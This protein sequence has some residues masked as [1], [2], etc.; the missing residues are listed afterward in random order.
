MQWLEKLKLGLAKT[1]AKITEGIDNV[2]NKRKLDEAVA[3]E[4][5]DLLISA[6][7]GIE[8]SQY[9]V[10]KLVDKYRFH[11]EVSLDEIKHT[12]AQLIAEIL[13]PIEHKEFCFDKK[14]KILIVCGVNGGGKTTSIAKLANFYKLQK[15]SVMLVACDTFRAAAVDQLEVWAN[16]LGITIIK[17]E[18]N[19]DPASVAY[20]GVKEAID[21]NIDLVIVD[22]AG[23][24]HNKDYLM[25]EMAKIIKTVQKLDEVSTAEIILVLDA[26]TGQNALTQVEKFQ[27]IAKLDSL[28]IT[29]L[30]GTA[31]GGIMVAIAKKYHI[32]VLAIGVGEGIDDLQPFVSENFAENLVGL[33]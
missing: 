19:A 12:L 18:Q 28:I 27:N 26:T 23:R 7:L 16:N 3:E 29:K 11:K 21:Q 25:A 33:K 13:K 20:K 6:D 4:L 24:L 17:G 32:P 30:D 31:K 15:K 2:I 10:K 22:T 14:P 1:S 5:E 8:V 9:L